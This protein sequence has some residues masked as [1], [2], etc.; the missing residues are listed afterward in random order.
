M[1]CCKW[2]TFI[3]MAGHVSGDI[4]ITHNYYAGP[5]IA[6]S[7]S[8]HDGNATDVYSVSC[9]VYTKS[10]IIALSCQFVSGLFVFSYNL[11]IKGRW[12]CLQIDKS[13]KNKV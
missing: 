4:Q 7:P 5:L 12:E 2:D 10:I 3:S 9:F 6:S 1:E 11:T 8:S 13:T